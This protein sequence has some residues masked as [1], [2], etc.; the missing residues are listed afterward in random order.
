MRRSLAAIAGFMIL[1]VAQNL[2][3]R[4]EAIDPAIATCADMTKALGGPPD[5]KADN[6][7][8]TRMG[9]QLLWMAGFLAPENQGTI[10]DLVQTQAD[11]EKIAIACTQTPT[12]GVKTVASKY[13]EKEQPTTPNSIDISTLKC[14]S[15]IEGKDERAAAATLWLIGNYAS[16]E[17]TPMFDMEQIGRTIGEIA[18]ECAKAPGLSLATAAEK[19]LE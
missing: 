6:S 12:L 15:L 11:I 4:A 14:S 5:A 16:D 8:Q 7:S 17:D 2:P 1:S 9:V 13:W 10:V 19:V 3:A 18:K